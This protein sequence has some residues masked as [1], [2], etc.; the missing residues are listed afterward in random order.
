MADGLASREERAPHTLLVAH[1]LGGLIVKQMLRRCSESLSPDFIEIGRSAT[2]VA[3]LATPHQGAQAAKTPD[4]LVRLFLSK[5]AKPLAYG[6]D[7]LV[8]LNDFFRSR[9]PR[10]S[11]AVSAYFET[12]KPKG[13]LV[14]ETVRGNT[15]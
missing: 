9:V 5:Q 13:V 4:V 2:G 8:D 10:Q 14:V 3:F 6:D 12:E 7:N 1:S 11:V 15:G